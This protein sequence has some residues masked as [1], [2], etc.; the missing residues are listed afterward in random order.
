MS[1]CVRPASICNSLICLIDY[2]QPMITS[3]F[4]S[5]AA[6]VQMSAPPD[7]SLKA[8]IQKELSSV[9]GSFALGFSGSANWRED[10]DQ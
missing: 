7:T 2:L 4:I 6:V 9:K 5:L 10:S 1:K 3:F 8:Q